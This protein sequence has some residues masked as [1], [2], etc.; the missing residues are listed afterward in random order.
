MSQTKSRKYPPEKYYRSFFVTRCDYNN[1][2]SSPKKTTPLGD[3]P[4]QNAPYGGPAFRL[5]VGGAPFTSFRCIET[6]SDS[7][8]RERWGMGLRKRTRLL[9]P[10][11]SETPQFVHL[12]DASPAGFRSMVDQMHTVG[13]FDMLI[14]SFGSGFNYEDTSPEYLAE[15]R[16]DVEYAK[17]RGIEVGGYD[18][19]SET[20]GGT[21]YDEVSP[22][23]HTGTGS[24]CMASHALERYC[25]GGARLELGLGTTHT[26]TGSACMVIAMACSP[27]RAV[28]LTFFGWVFF[29]RKL[30]GQ[31]PHV[32]CTPMGR[33][34]GEPNEIELTAIVVK[35]N[36]S[37]C[38][39]ATGTTS[40]SPKS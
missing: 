6:Y 25:V 14:F 36:G 10:Q 7:L 13:G 27:K 33:T 1:N 30:G 12:T 40:S 31:A 5:R 24:A 26:G 19:I 16:G 39:P 37:R 32:R 8:D 17:A 29:L 18:L 35:L 9:A 38:R 2:A 3:Y 34:C 15:I 21:G 4:M 28:T 11:T 20:R 22:T 23:T